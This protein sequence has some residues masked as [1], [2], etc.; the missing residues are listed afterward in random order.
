MTNNQEEGASVMKDCDI[1]L[2]VEIKK[3]KDTEVENGIK[4]FNGVLEELLVSKSPETHQNLT[5]APPVA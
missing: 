3:L 4:F 1:E 2:L 5:S